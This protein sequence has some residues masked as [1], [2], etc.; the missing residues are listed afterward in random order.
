LRQGRLQASGEA[1]L[2]AL[3]L[4]PER[5]VQSVDLGPAAPINLAIWQALAETQRAGLD[6]D[7]AWSRVGDL[8]LRPLVPQLASRRTWFFSP[9]GEL[10]RVPFAALA[11]KENG[12]LVRYGD[13]HNIRLLTSAREL[14]QPRQAGDGASQAALVLA[15]PYFEAAPPHAET[16]AATASVRT[17]W[18]AP[19]PEAWRRL[20]WSRL[21]G[22]RGEGVTLRGLLNAQLL[23]DASATSAAL[24]AAR[25]PSILH[26]ATHGAFLAAARSQATSDQERQQALEGKSRLWDDPMQRAVLVLA[27]ANRSNRSEQD[28]GYFTATKTSLL[29]LEGTSLVTLSACDSGKGT[30]ELGD[31]VYGLR[32]ALAVA[33]AQSSLLSLWKVDDQATRALMESFYL[34]LRSGKSPEQALRETQQ[35]MRE[36]PRLEWRHPYVWAAFQL[37][38]LSW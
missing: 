11:R 15:D 24:E 2:T 6:S 27:G 34:H 37:Y 14:L 36:H 32:R 10:H 19:L 29:Q 13:A 3:V 16:T 25:S 7:T 38:G 12:A 5:N 1:R 23:T 26:V 18:V 21:P 31:G 17:D 9:D 20:R 8:V 35:L 33:G 30:I 4:T 22:S 28:A